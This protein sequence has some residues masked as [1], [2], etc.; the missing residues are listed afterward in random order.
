VAPPGLRIAMSVVILGNGV[1]ANAAASAITASGRDL[2]ITMVSAEAHPH[3]SACVLPHYLSGEI[4]RERVFL[5]TAADYA[6]EGISTLFGHRAVAIDIGERRLLLEDRSLR[7]D[8]LILA[9][10]SKP[11][12]PP[13]EG[14]DKEGVFTF[15]SLADADALASY[16]GETAVVVGSGPIGIEAS[17]ALKKRGWRVFLV[18]LLDWI[19]PRVFDR[20]PAAMLQEILERE[21]I[22]VLTGERVV[23][24]LGE[25]RVSGVATARREIACDLVLMVA[26]MVPEVELARRAGLEVGGLGGLATDEH[27]LTTGADIYACGDCIEARDVV[28]G[29]RTLS[30]LWHNARE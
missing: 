2:P 8:K 10:G 7:Y 30:L 16:G 1:A 18:E 23:R 29:E 27:L 5:K 12:V 20:E 4:A 21:Q 17:I 24:I 15:K 11:A 22:E 6:R 19:L 28:S 13:I 26:G 14:V 25:G 9:S 3:Y